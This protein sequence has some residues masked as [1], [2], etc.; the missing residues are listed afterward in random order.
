MMFI[1]I[2]YLFNYVHSWRL[3]GVVLV[4]TGFAEVVVAVATPV[5]S[6]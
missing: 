5:S 6:S 1:K 2:G 3:M 4:V